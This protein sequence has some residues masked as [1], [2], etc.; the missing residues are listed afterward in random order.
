MTTLNDQEKALLL[1]A[2]ELATAVQALLDKQPESYTNLTTALH[3]FRIAQ[4]VVDKA[5]AK[6]LEAMEKQHY[7]LLAR[8][9]N[10]T[11]CN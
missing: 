4:V 7:E 3:N 2:E 10:K 6:E 8:A 1:R 11:F 5:F 9:H